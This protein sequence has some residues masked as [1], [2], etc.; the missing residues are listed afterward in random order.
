MAMYQQIFR[1]P[2]PLTG[3]LIPLALQAS[4]A[5]QGRTLFATHPKIICIVGNFHTLENCGADTSV[6]LVH[7]PLRLNT[8]PKAYLGAMKNVST[9]KGGLPIPFGIWL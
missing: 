6:L 2:G 3:V 9:K 7:G 1:H 8:L 5:P 4:P